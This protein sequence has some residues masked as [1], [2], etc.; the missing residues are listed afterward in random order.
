M[1][2]LTVLCVSVYGE[3]K[4]GKLRV[5]LCVCICTVRSECVCVF[6]VLVILEGLWSFGNGSYVCVWVC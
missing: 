4:G 2:M 5:C 1:V 6:S 3:Q